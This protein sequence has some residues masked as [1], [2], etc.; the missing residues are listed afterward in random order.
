MSNFRITPIGTCRIHTPLRRAS[1]R[2]PVSLDLRRNYGFVHTSAEALQ[3]LRFLQGEKEFSAAAAPLVFRGAD[4]EAFNNEQWQAS[5]LH[6]V[7]IS[8]SKKISC[9]ADSVQGNYVQRYFSDFF[10]GRER[11]RNF[12]NLVKM[13]HRQDLVDFLE[14]QRS[15]QLLSPTDQRLLS[16]LSMEQLSF[17]AIKS[18]MSEILD[19]LGRD[20]VLF[21]THVNALAPD[22]E[23]IPTRDR[24]IRWVKM[25]A[26]QLGAE[27]F[28]P[29][30]T[31]N[32][33]GQEAALENNGLDLTHYNLP[34]SDL[35]Y[36]KMHRAH[37]SSRITGQAGEEA[38]LSSGHELGNLA[39][40]LEGDLLS[41]NFLDASRRVYSAVEES[42][43]AV[44]FIELR[45][46]IRSKIG[47]FSGALADLTLRGDNELLS[48]N[49]R[50]ALLEA[51]TN[52]GRSD[53]ALRV[54]QQ[55]I[56]DE[57]EDSEV[58]RSAADAAQQTGNIRLAIR[59]FKQA[60][61]KNRSDLATA[62]HALILLRESPDNDAEAEEWRREMLENIGTGSSGAFELAT[63]A[64]EHKDDDLFAAAFE[65]VIDHDRG[66][67]MDLAEDALEARMIRG[68]AST[69][70][71]LAKRGK[72]PTGLSVRRLA[73]YDRAIDELGRLLEQNRPAEANEMARL[74]AQ[75]GQHP[76]E[77]IPA[78]KIEAKA[79]RAMGHITRHVR[80]LVRAS[81]SAGNPDDVVENAEGTEDILAGDPDTAVIVARSLDAVGRKE[82]ALK[83]LKSAQAANPDHFGARRL[84]AR[85]ATQ[86]NDYATAI[87]LYSSLEQFEEFPNAQQEVVRFFGFAERRALKQLRL[88]GDQELYEEALRLASSIAR[89]FGPLERT[90]R[91]LLRMSRQL[92][93]KLKE[94]DEVG[95]DLEDRELIL[96]RL[97]DIGF[98]SEKYLRR[99][100][101]EL[102]RQFRFAEAAEI[103]EKLH[104]VDPENETAVRNR[105]RCATLAERR[106]SISGAEVNEVG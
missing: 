36:D 97:V 10:A 3:L 30:D 5:D 7:E 84:A 24:L 85:Y 1:A 80:T 94:I 50:L 13:G 72:L 31:M 6:V 106:A 56:A 2:Y 98:D 74:L 15:Y 83:L 44:P 48:H 54:A 70:P 60:S 61:R 28:D 75:I 35:L 71:L 23:Q 92:R 40:K 21:V 49:M 42:P 32:D 18:D 16:E 91:E 57:F 34:F 76:T 64:I 12:W 11:A 45:G 88:L 39:L 14:A 101:L 82:E 86:Q 33:V 103:W 67:A 53:E 93:L 59:Y 47:D 51:L 25:A 89:R 55:L 17:K 29:T 90:K 38:D 43:D 27:V 87:D 102:M 78:E 105:V 66:G 9:G 81:F 73:L 58:Y 79:R 19:R 37:V 41:G 104:I 26:D 62:L 22:G 4:P 95:N 46:L 99:L 65:A 8:S 69:L 96:R 63:W 77:Q 68:A 100:A 52:R 20:K